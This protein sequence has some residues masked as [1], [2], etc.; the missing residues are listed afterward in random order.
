[1]R[2]RERT[3]PRRA[4]ACIGASREQD[5]GQVAGNAPSRIFGRVADTS[6]RGPTAPRRGKQTEGRRVEE[7]EHN[8]GRTEV[9][10]F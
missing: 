6:G 8:T 1:M 10:S 3:R 2:E 7:G 9:C 4:V 5:G